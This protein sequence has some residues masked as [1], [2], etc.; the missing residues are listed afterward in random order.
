M[1]WSSCSTGDRSFGP[2]PKVSTLG[3]NEMCAVSNSL[4]ETSRDTLLL[5]VCVC[6]CVRAR[7]RVV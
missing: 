6:V 3:A 2:R 7:A 1:S 5:N 4:S